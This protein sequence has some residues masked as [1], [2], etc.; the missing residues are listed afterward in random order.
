M[1][2]MIEMA[3]RLSRISIEKACDVDHAFVWP[4]EL[5]PGRWC[6]SPELVSLYGTKVWDGLSEQRRRELSFH[7]VVNFFSVVLQRERPLV[8]GL[9]E[10]LYGQ[11]CSPE[12]SAYL[13]HVIE[14]ENRHMAMFGRF[15]TRYAGKVY[16]DKKVPLEQDYAPGEEE[17]VFFCKMLVVEELGDFYNRYMMHDARIEPIVRDLNRAHHVD[18][19]RHLVFGRAHLRELFARW[20]PHWSPSTRK[21]LREWLCGYL[22]LSWGDFYSPAMYAD[23]G[24]DDGFAMRD[25]ALSSPACVSHRRLASA[26]LVKVLLSASIL[27]GVPAS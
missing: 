10:R 3:P 27:E 5:D 11:A 16:P 8:Q 17:V 18:E 14:E 20:S 25:V 24:F 2:P 21:D 23:A 22:R 7:E 4:D 6:M 9:T 12:L 13:H 26:R 15:C 1:Q 19:S